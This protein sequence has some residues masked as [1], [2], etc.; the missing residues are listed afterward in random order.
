[1]IL[2]RFPT[3][4]KHWEMDDQRYPKNE[5]WNAAIARTKLTM[6]HFKD[7]PSLSA[8][9]V[10]DGSHLDY[11]DTRRF[12]E[13]LLEILDNELPLR[14][15]RTQSQWKA[16]WVGGVTVA[17]C[18]FRSHKKPSCFTLIAVSLHMYVRD[19]AKS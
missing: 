10:P 18:P 2:V 1:M 16:S 3:S 19:E 6:I 11:R 13:A 15:R 5:Y 8:F 14:V 7:F 4:G 12:T 17:H 9:D